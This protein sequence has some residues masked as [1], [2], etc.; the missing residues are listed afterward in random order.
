MLSKEEYLKALSVVENY[1]DV[2]EMIKNREIIE[3]LI[4]EHFEMLDKIKT[5]ELS[6]GYHTFNELYYHRAVLFSIICNEHKDVAYKSKEHHDGTMYDGMFIVGINTPQGQY[7]YHYDLNV[8]SMFDVPE[9]EFAPEWDGHKPSDI[10]RLISINNPQP[11]KFEDLKEGMWVWDNQLKWCFEIAICI[12][13]IKG[14]ENL[15]MFKVKNYDDSLTLMIF[16]EN[17][18]YPVQMANVRCE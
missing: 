10:E 6:D 8:W 15:K 7:S 16:E 17:R 9:L 3:N 18:F 2:D 14:Y 1:D 4:K 13:E 11:Y 5:G 12:V